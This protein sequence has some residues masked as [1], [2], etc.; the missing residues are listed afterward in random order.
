MTNHCRTA[1]SISKPKCSVRGKVR[2]ILLEESWPVF[3]VHVTNALVSIN[4]ASSLA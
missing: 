3:A 1:P 4:Y 2:L